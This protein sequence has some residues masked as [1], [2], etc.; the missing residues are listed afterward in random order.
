MVARAQLGAVGEDRGHHRHV[1]RREAQVLPRHHVRVGPR[2]EAP[3]QL[4]RVDVQL[5]QEL[6]QPLVA[7]GERRRER[8]PLPGEQRERLG[9][10]ALREPAGED[11]VDD[12]EVRQVGVAVAEVAQD[13]GDVRPALAEARGA[14]GLVGE[15]DQVGEIGRR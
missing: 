14:R 15:P 1:G 5:A 9:A 13:L 8:E 12:V 2:R 11:L 4:D 6:P 10:A 3:V 7:E